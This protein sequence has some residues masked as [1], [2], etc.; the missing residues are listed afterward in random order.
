MDRPVRTSARVGGTATRANGARVR[1]HRCQTYEG[2]LGGLPGAEAHGAYTFCGLGALHLLGRTDTID[3]ARLLVRCPCARLPAHARARSG[4][5]SSS[6]AHRTGRHTGRCG[7][8]AASRAAPTSSW[9][10]ATRTGWPLCFL[11]S[12]VRLA[13]IRPLRPPP[14]RA[15]PLQQWPQQDLR[16]TCFTRVRRMPARWCGRVLT[17]AGAP[18]GSPVALQHYILVCAQNAS[19][20]FV[21]R[22]GR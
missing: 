11:C 21:D 22:P 19:G 17:G 5:L 14:P 15:H 7:W 4:R 2:G 16:P 10:A 12:P 6:A 13:L 8:R 20:G 1:A 3:C 18:T 9:T